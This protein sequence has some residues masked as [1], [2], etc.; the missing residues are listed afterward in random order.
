MDHQPQI[1][2]SQKTGQKYWI[3][4]WVSFSFIAFLFCLMFGFIGML[5]IPFLVPIAQMI[6]LLK[7]QNV[8]LAGLW[9]TRP[10]L[11]FILMMLNTH[12]E[13]F[14]LLALVLDGIL[15][16]YIL[17]VMFRK[18]L[19]VIYA[20]THIVIVVLLFYLIENFRDYIWFDEIWIRLSILTMIFLVYTI[21]GGFILDRFYKRKMK[22]S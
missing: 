7:I 6:A 18:A 11:W 19:N 13:L 21:I 22:L 15:A 1:N 8:S 3:V 17:S 2:S 20:I 14:L 4:Y 10:L 9:L 16:E 5:V 12:D